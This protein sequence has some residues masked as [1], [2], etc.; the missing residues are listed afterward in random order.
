MRCSPCYIASDLRLWELAGG[1]EP[2]TCCLQ[3]SCAAGCATPAGGERV[4]DL[5]PRVA[6]SA[7]FEEG[8]GSGDGGVEAFDLAGHG[9]VDEDVAGVPDQAVE[10]GAFA[11]DHDADGFVGELEGEQACVGGAVEADA[12]DAGVAELFDGAGEV[13]DLGDGEVL[14]GAGGGLHRHGG[15]GGAAVAGEDQAVA[16][17]GFGA[18][19][20]G[21]EVVGVFDAVEGEE[22]GGLAARQGDGQELGQADG[23]DGGHDGEDALVG[24]AAGLGVDERAGDGLDLDTAALG[25]VQQVAEGGSA[26]AG[27]EQDPVDGAAGAQGLDDRAAALDQGPAGAGADGPAGGLKLVAAAGLLGPAGGGG[28]AALLGGG[29]RAPDLSPIGAL[30]AAGAATPGA[31][32]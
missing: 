24:A 22:E 19:G 30:G 7:D 26:G 9:D 11:A 15:Q 16:A 32:A 13:G 5:G 10:A 27:G 4:R 12:P 3:D 29:L 25:Q 31:A 21:A 20:Q 23:L 2:P 14:Q 1:L 6:A 18:A 28:G 8:E 17:G